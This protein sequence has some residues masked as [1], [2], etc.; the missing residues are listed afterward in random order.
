MPES[1]TPRLGAAQIDKMSERE[2]RA[3]LN[4]V[5]VDLT[6]LK[7]QL[8]Q[9]ITDYNANATIATDTTAVAPTL[10]LTA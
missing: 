10:T 2:V 3:L 6:A 8:A 1:I 7:A 5:L 9:L 4:A